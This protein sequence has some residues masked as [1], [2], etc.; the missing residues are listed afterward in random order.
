MDFFPATNKLFVTNKDATYTF[1]FELGS[2]KNHRDYHGISRIGYEQARE[3]ARDRKKFEITTTILKGRSDRITLIKLGTINE[4][5]IGTRNGH[6][7]NPRRTHL[8]AK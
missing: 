8:T 4:A 3:M 2:L 5:P 1:W 7:A 6:L